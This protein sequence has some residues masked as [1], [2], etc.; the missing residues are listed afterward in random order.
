MSAG[1]PIGKA[2]AVVTLPSTDVTPPVQ[3]PTPKDADTFQHGGDH[4]A[5]GPSWV[6]QAR[7]LTRAA[8]ATGLDEDHSSFAKL[9]DQIAITEAYDKARQQG[10]R[11]PSGIT[12]LRDAVKPVQ[13]PID[14]KSI[15]A[16]P[17]LKEL[18]ELSYTDWI[19]KTERPNLFQH[20]TDLYAMR[21]TEL[22]DLAKQFQG[23]KHNGTTDPVT[24]R[25]Q[26]R[27]VQQRLI[28][29]DHEEANL[30]VHKKY[31]S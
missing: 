23:Q 9:S 30:D 14:P 31:L 1:P 21:R 25:Q 7:R 12:A 16:I 20:I 2:K 10:R 13:T 27:L 24:A 28:E 5:L 15:P 19:D 6:A 3:P 11:L 4:F 8:T 17:T 22:E 18:L 29:L 26:L